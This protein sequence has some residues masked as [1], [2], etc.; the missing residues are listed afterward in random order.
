MRLQRILN[1]K[2]QGITEYG[3]ILLFVVLLGASEY[4]SGNIGQ[5]ISLLYS[6]A[7]DHLY[8]IV[9]GPKTDYDT[10]ITFT[11]SQSNVWHQTSL[12][13]QTMNGINDPTKDY[14][15][16]WFINDGGKGNKEYKVGM[17][18]RGGDNSLQAYL[19]GTSYFEDT[20]GNYYMLVESGGSNTT[21]AQ[22]SSTSIDTHKMRNVSPAAIPSL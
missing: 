16:Y 9:N 18:A 7:S 3:I 13:Y 17:S 11:D 14:R 5:N 21:I 1:K 6:A 19:G 15:V 20:N 10:G 2:G 4:Y 22:V 12:T 8:S